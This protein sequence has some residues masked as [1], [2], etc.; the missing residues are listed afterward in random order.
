MRKT[1]NIDKMSEQIWFKD[2]SVLFGPTTWNRFV[3]TKDMS[4]ADALN[5]VV[6]FTTYFSIL[7]FIS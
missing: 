5:S 4:T 7:L 6:R 1:N 2:P 3:P